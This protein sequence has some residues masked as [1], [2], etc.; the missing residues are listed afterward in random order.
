M[1]RLTLVLL[2]LLGG[3]SAAEPA[4]WRFEEL[5]RFP[6]PE[7]RQGVASDGEFLYVITN[8]TIGKYR[9]ATGERV[10]RWEGAAGGPIIHLN[11]GIVREGKLYCAHSNYPT[12]PM[13]SSV[14]IFDTA[15]LKPAGS[16]KFGRT[17]GSLTW[18]DR[19][20]GQWIACFVHYGGRGGV[21]GRGPEWTRL[22]AF[23]DKW[24]PTGGSWTLPADLVAKIGERG[25][26]VSGG[27]FGPDGLL[28][29]TGHDNPELYVLNVPAAH[30][31]L[32]W[33]ATI[34]VPIEG[35]AFGWDPRAKG[36]IYF[37][38]RPG[39]VIVGKITPP[40]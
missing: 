19:R 40:K 29:A 13:E 37:I 25:Y 7:A 20:N 15:T 26:S 17:D 11:A 23:D 33:T 4:G 18:I 36:V 27:A 39:E 14:E 24:Q 38:K 28:Y 8:R 22:V 5:R 2:A 10:A 31:V 16:H 21:P 35:Q 12:V 34:P 9:A 32:R 30:P 1:L 6:A 3:L